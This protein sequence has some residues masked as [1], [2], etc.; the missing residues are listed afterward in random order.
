LNSLEEEFISSFRSLLVRY[1]IIIEE[2]FDNGGQDSSYILHNFSKD[3]DKSIRISVDNLI[4][5][6]LSK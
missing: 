3:E 2:E 5:E 1:G 4:E 6:I